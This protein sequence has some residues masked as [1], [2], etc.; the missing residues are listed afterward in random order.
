MC[1]GPRLTILIGP[2]ARFIMTA[3]ISLS[4]IMDTRWVT[5]LHKL[6]AYTI[7]LIRA[8]SSVRTLVRSIR[9][10]FVEL[11]ALPRWIWSVKLAHFV[12]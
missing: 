3:R 8:I 12:H 11:V 2:N 6:Y 9:N 7:F 5:L 1:M 10:I 4:L